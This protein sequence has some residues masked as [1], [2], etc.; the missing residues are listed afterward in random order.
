MDGAMSNFTGNPWQA[1]HDMM[2]SH[3][4]ATAVT[5]EPPA[6]RFPLSDHGNAQRFAAENS[7]R[8][9]YSFERGSW[10]A[11]D[12]KVWRYD[13]S[14]APMRAAKR[15]NRNLIRDASQASSDSDRQAMLD[16][17]RKCEAA[18]RLKA[19]VELARDELPVTFDELDADP[20]LL[21]VQN[22]T[23]DLR[24]GKLRDHDATDLIT[25]LA[26]VEHDA[27]ATCPTF[28]RFIRRIF[29]G[30]T[31]LIAYIQR[32]LGYCLTGD[33]REQIMP[34]CHGQGANGKSTLLDMVVWL[35]GDYA[36][37]A[38]PDLLIQRR[39]DE[40]PTELADLC[41]KRLIVASE[42]EKHRRLKVQLV[43]RLTG[44]ATIKARFMRQDYFSFN[45][46]FKV[47]LVTN[48]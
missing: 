18:T 20:W 44:D 40:H 33:V 26:P 37:D 39:G 29:D 8:L 23:L 24:T 48:T 5:V 34:V 38:P 9:R 11:C 35:L 36:S 15:C 7:G 32:W 45:R 25:K 46:T 16:H 2:R 3:I 12:G 43:K 19:M 1:E 41:G 42:S 27:A 4:K 10:L 6:E 28:D 47:A 31:T 14:G 30:D 21:N 22:G 17:A 13:N